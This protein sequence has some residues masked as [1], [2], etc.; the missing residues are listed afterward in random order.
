MNVVIKEKSLKI[1]D[2]KFEIKKIGFIKSIFSFYEKGE[3]LIFQSNNVLEVTN[4]KEF[5]RKFQLN[6]KKA[7]KVNKIYFDL[8]K[9][10]ETDKFSIFN[11]YVN[12]KDS[13][14]KH[15]EPTYLK[16]MQLFKSL[17]NS[18]LN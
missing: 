5:A 14:Q 7:E 6:L 11:I 18:I 15:K 2:A 3:E 12:K 9:N 13:E 8:E 1:E 16:N 17:L 10:I 4:K